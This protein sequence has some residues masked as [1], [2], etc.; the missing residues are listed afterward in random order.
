MLLLYNFQ[1]IYRGQNYPISGLIVSELLPS[2]DAYMTYE[3]STTYPGC[4]ESV[5]WVVMNRPVYLTRQELDRLRLLMQGDKIHPKAPLA[6]NVR[7]IQELRERSV[8]TNIAFSNGGGR[9]GG[10]GNSRHG[11]DKAC[12]DVAKD[13]FYK[14]NAGWNKGR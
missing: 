2:T 13:T 7:P 6:K 11:Q 14:A 4:W 12:P 8:R 5:T 3:G 1:V 9:N 10:G